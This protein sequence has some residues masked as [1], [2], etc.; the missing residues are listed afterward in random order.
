MRKKT[1][2]ILAVILAVC[3][4]CSVPAYYVRADSI[5]DQ[6]DQK[7][8]E[9]SSGQS[10]LAQ[11]A[12]QLNEIQG[13]IDKTEAQ[14]SSL[15]KKVDA[16]EVKINKMAARIRKQKK[17]L[18]ESQDQLDGRLRNMYKSG[19]VGFVQVILSSDDVT[20]LLSNIAMVKKIFEND[21]NV[22]ETMTAKY[23][24]LKTQQKELKEM[25]A[26]LKAQKSEITAK[27]STLSSQKSELS[28]KKNT[29]AASNEKI[30][31]EISELQDEADEL[32][33]TGNGSSGGSYSGGALAWPCPSC[34]NISCGFGWRNCPFH[35]WECHTGIDISASYGASITAAASGTVT[36]ASYYGSFGNAVKIS[37]GGGICTLYGHCSRLLVSSGQHVKKGQVI[38]KVGSTGNSTGPHLHFSVIKNGTYVNPMNYL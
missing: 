15:N 18:D 14:L 6:I 11:V 20:E 1:S 3:M 19:S 27:K 35:G 34:S 22:V 12:E 28:A 7:Q 4:T 31:G 25:Q 23:N 17:K 26:D 21:Q 16:Q 29:I 32:A 8:S 33:N 13:K 38:A 2:I 24:K 30:S 10:K 5:N 9:L 37:H 36:I